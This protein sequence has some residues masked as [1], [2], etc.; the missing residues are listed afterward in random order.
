MEVTR[1]A[2]P[3]RART[4]VVMLPGALSKPQEFVDE[5]WLRALHAERGLAAD[6][7]LVDAHIGYYQERSILDRLRRDVIEPARAQG[8]TRIWLAGISI[9]GF[10]ALGY[11]AR[12][13]GEVDGVLAVAP[14]LGRRLLL[15]EIGDAGGP[16]RWRAATVQPQPSEG[17][18]EREIW[19]Q[20]AGGDTSR[21]FI[22]YGRDD[23]FAD[24]QGV[25]AGLVGERGFSVPG[26]HDWPA[27]RP[28]WS[29]WLDRGL[30]APRCGA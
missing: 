25:A 18:L 10:G 12:H 22:G 23:R 13:P 30:L 4:L 15:K 19:W 14:Y 27:W 17:D 9:G 28:L 26:G 29:Q 24:A 16:A 11:A 3:C 20:L 2:A 1:V 5:G 6:A 8:Y 21:W 7:W